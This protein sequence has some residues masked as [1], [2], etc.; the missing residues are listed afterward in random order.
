M[1]SAEWGTAKMIDRLAVLP[2]VLKFAIEGF[3]AALEGGLEL[4]KVADQDD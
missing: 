3:D 4:G 2:R 1:R